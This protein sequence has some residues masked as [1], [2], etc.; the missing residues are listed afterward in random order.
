MS[1]ADDCSGNCRG[2]RWSTFLS[3]EIYD[4]NVTELVRIGLQADQL[5]NPY[6]W[7]KTYSYAQV[8]LT[9]SNPVCF[10]APL[11]AHPMYKDHPKQ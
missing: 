7:C 11:P 2:V 6:D 5:L 1:F 9:D 10:S 3:I 8:T 4:L